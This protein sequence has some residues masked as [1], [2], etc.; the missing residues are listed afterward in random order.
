[1]HCINISIKL[2][3]TKQWVVEK[4]SRCGSRQA[5]LIVLDGKSTVCMYNN[6]KDTK[7]TRHIYRRMHFVRNGEEWNIHKTVWCELG[8]K[9]AD[10][11]TK[12]VREDEFNPIL[13]YCML[14]LD[15]I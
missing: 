12:N 2:Q 13:I 11:R 5:P 7:H 8:L 3:G 6:G 4:G 9:L 10:I 1:M 14:K 15:N